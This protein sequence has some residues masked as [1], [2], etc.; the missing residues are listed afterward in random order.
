MPTCCLTT[1]AWKL[2][3]ILRSQHEAAA[4]L[5]LSCF[6]RLTVVCF[7]QLAHAVCSLYP[8]IAAAAYNANA[9]PSLRVCGIMHKYLSL[10][11]F[12]DMSSISG[13]VRTLSTLSQAWINA[14]FHLELTA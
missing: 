8:I 13:G 14:F 11:T 5:F 7:P 6:H 1:N 10:C 3:L 4:S 12:S 2:R 9:L